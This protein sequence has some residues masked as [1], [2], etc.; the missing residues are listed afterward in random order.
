MKNIEDMSYAEYREMAE[1][2]IYDLF[3]D[4]TG[5]NIGKP[6]TTDDNS[7]LIDAASFLVQSGK[8]VHVRNDEFA[9]K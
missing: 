7:H 5:A 2:I 3:R 8:I 1:E 6:M 4:L 9:K